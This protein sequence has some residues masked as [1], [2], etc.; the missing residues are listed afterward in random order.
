MTEQS[1]FLFFFSFAQ[2]CCTY[3]TRREAATLPFSPLFAHRVKEFDEFLGKGS[4]PPSLLASGV[5]SE[6]VLFFFFLIPI[7]PAKG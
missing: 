6:S 5:R 2:A 7:G 1:R 4:A 3:S